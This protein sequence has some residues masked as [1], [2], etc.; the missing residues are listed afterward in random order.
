MNKLLQI[1]C[2][3]RSK[4]CGFMIAE[5][6][7]GSGGRRI[8]TDGNR[9]YEVPF[10]WAIVEGCP[11]HGRGRDP[12]GPVDRVGLIPIPGDRV[13]EA[14]KTRVRVLKWHPDDTKAA[15]ENWGGTFS[16]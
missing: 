16:W 7:E 2:V 11:R 6:V 14:L 10:E 4:G 1:V 3:A 13:D 15:R 5:V 8:L 12:S 9:S